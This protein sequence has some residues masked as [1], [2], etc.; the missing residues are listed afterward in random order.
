MII[1][2]DNNLIIFFCSNQ[3]RYFDK[4]EPVIEARLVAGGVR[5]HQIL[6]AALPDSQVDLL[7]VRLADRGND[8]NVRKPVELEK[9]DDVRVGQ[10]FLA[11]TES[12]EV[13]QW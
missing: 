4:A 12:A 7:Q 13:I 6:A 10:G 3:R 1:H 8:V 11:R 9:V 5:L 2:N